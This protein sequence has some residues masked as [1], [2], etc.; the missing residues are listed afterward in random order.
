MALSSALNANPIVTVADAETASGWRAAQ[1]LNTGSIPGYTSKRQWGLQVYKIALV[2]NS[3]TPAA[4]QITVSDPN[5]GT[6]LWS[7]ANTATA[8]TIGEVLLNEHLTSALKWR[9]WKVV[10][11]T[12]SSCALM[13][14]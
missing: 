11:L 5:D 13:V 10:G 14:W 9:D 12:A 4:A 6:V 2:A 8:A 3:A 1:T 7:A